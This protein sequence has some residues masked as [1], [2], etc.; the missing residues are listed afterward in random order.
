MDASINQDADVR[1][2]KDGVMTSDGRLLLALQ[3]I[4]RRSSPSFPWIEAVKHLSESA[5]PV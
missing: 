4:F 3:V 2:F 1:T 5:L